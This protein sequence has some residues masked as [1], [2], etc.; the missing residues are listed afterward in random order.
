MALDPEGRDVRSSFAPNDI[1]YVVADLANAPRGTKFEAKWIAVNA[2]GASPNFEFQTQALDLSDETLT[3]K[4][5]FQLANDHPWPAGQYRVD[6]YLN[7]AP[8]GSAGFSV[9]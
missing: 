3:G 8:V 4:I 1:F 7:G 6:L 2:T 9:Q 5:Y